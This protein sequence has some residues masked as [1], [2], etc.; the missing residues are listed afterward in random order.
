MVDTNMGASIAAQSPPPP[1]AALDAA[2]VSRGVAH[3]RLAS[4]AEGFSGAMIYSQNC[5]DALGRQFS[6]A[7]LDRCGAFD[8][9]AA[10]SI[11]AA[12][13]ADL[14]TENDYFQSEAV[15]GRY[16]AAAT[17]AGQEAGAAD[18]R[19]ADLQRRVGGM[20]IAAQPT[21]A[22][23][24]N[25]VVSADGADGMGDSGESDVP[26]DTDIDNGNRID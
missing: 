6:W 11:D 24:E 20:R 21:P 15:A 10:R 12:E 14:T 2:S 22:D 18:T 7:Q 23:T 26:M 25:E 3:M 16:L 1:P 13:P 19:L 8:V 4:G 17:G 5:Y 9:I